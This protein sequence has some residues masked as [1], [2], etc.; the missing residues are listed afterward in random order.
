M[1]LHGHSLFITAQFLR[2]RWALQYLRHC[3][4]KP[5]IPESDSK[6]QKIPT[7]YTGY[8]KHQLISRKYKRLTALLLLVLATVEF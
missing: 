2:L 1:V 6:N 3:G 7:K 4:R 5:N 8:N